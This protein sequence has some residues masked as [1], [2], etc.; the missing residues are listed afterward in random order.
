MCTQS[1]HTQQPFKRLSAI[2]WWEWILKAFRMMRFYENHFTPNSGTRSNIK[3]SIFIETRG[4]WM[5]RCGKPT[6][7]SNIW[8]TGGARSGNQ[9]LGLES[10]V[11]NPGFQH[12]LEYSLPLLKTSK[13]ARFDFNFAP[14]AKILR[15]GLSWLA[16]GSSNTI[17]YLRC[18]F[19]YIAKCS[20][21][22]KIVKTLNTWDQCPRF[23][24]PFGHLNRIFL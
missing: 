23:F 13:F 5:R 21:A 19:E 6:Q 9:P 24:F 8:K 2:Q 20:A 15:F 12:M 3:F 4:K 14:L 18:Q 10:L 11:L 16:H 7:A 17:I 1:I 22:K